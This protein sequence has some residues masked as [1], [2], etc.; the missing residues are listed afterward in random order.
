LTSPLQNPDISPRALAGRLIMIRFPGTTLDADTAEFI[1]RNHIRAVCLFRANMTDSAQVRQLTSD[2]RAAMGPR[3]SQALIAIDQEGGAVVRATWLPAPPSAM[4]LGAVDDVALAHEVGAAVARGIK[5]L[6]FNWNFAPVLDLNNNLNNPV[7]AERSFGIDPQRVTALAGAWMAGSLAEGVACC[8]KHA[9]GHGDTHVDS[10]RDLPTVDKPLDALRALEFAPFKH[11][12]P[13][14]PAMMTAHIIF[15]ALD[16]KLPATLSARILTGLIR[17]EWQFNGVVITDGMDMQAI[18]GNYGVG[19]AALLSLQA[20]SD[21]V[22]AL[23]DRETQETTLAA[24]E[25][26][27]MQGD[28]SPLQVQQRLHR[29]DALAQR[30]PSLPPATLYS[31]AQEAADHKLMQN[32]WRRA[33]TPYRQPKAP[34]PGSKV[35]VVIKADASSDGVSEAGLSAQQ[36]QAWLSA[37][38]DMAI[39]TFTQQEQF[40]WA[41]LPADGRMVILAST[42][43]TRYAAHARETWHPDLHLC[44]WNPF[45][46]LDID[47]PAVVC[48]GFAKPVLQALEEWFLGGLKLTGRNPCLAE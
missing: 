11:I 24:L 32:A 39:S 19:H 46:A 47:A 22:M 48:Y 40:N 29:L 7:I 38:Y 20:G 2:L 25:Q 18:A 21:M 8:V 10:H 37:H 44:L 30:Y 14:A 6:G 15:P 17:D 31:A 27:I 42:S 43:R 9:P 26:G 3:A 23:G 28:I 1:R 5:D 16:A 12:A 33:L 36:L 35:R 34:A 45:Q 13:D 4:A 41:D